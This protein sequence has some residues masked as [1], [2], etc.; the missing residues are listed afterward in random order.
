MV[1]MYLELSYMYVG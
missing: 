1:M